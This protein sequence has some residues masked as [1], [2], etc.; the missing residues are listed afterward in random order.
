MCTCMCARF[1]TVIET[2]FR[3]DLEKPR[4]QK[5]MR[6]F[7]ETETDIG[8]TQQINMNQ[9]AIRKVDKWGLTS[10]PG[11]SQNDTMV[12]FHSMSAQR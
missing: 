2:F 10:R 6:Q 7:T 8:I 11:L 4:Y 1:H 5:N 9:P 12:T 3:L